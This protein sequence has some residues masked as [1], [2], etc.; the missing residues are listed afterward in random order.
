[1]AQRTQI[2]SYASDVSKAKL[3]IHHWESGEHWT[4][5]NTI[6]AIERWLSERG[7][8]FRIALEPTNTYHELFAQ[9]LY[10]H[11]HEVYLVN[12]D[13]LAHYRKAVSVNAKTD[14]VDAQLIARYLVHEGEHLRRYKP[15]SD[16]HKSLWTLLK[17]R[18]ALV[19][20]KTALTSSLK[21]N[22]DLDEFTP[23]LFGSLNACLKNLERRLYALA[24]KLG[25]AESMKRCRQVPGV[26]PLTALAITLAFERG[27]FKSVD[28]FVA[29]LGLDVRVRDSGKSKGR[30]KLTKKGD[31]EMRRILFNAARAGA[32]TSTW[33][34]YYQGLRDR[35]LASTA[36]CV[37]LSRKLV[38][39]LFALLTKCTDFNPQMHNKACAQ[40]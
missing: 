26:G 19:K 17:R 7:G 22:K 27:K 13:C 9:L 21:G 12:T 38:K 34:S 37:A 10:E 25:Y 23:A 16:G 5:P 30:R 39:V 2:D 6:E 36:A 33:G 8:M 18:A 29:F 35:G 1:M 31:G 15:L 28:A 11:G 3:D 32:R 20:A 4:I 40:T 14:R 24:N